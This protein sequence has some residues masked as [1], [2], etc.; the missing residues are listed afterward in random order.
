[1]KIYND[2]N[3]FI[4]VKNAIVTIGTFDGVHLGHQAIFKKMVDDAKA[5][6]GETVVVTFYPHPRLV[7]NIDSSNLKF[8]TTQEKKLSIFAK[9]GIDNV[10]I[11]HFTREFSRTGSEAFIKNYIVEK[12]K[13]ACIVVGYDHHFGKNRIGDFKL[14]YDLSNKYHFK[15]ERIPAHDVE[16]ISVSSTKI[17]RALV[18]GDVK[19]ANRLLGYEY[20]NCGIVVHGNEIGRKIGFPTANIF[21]AEQYKLISVCGVYAC[22]VAYNGKI[23]DG[24]GNVGVRPTIGNDALTIEVHIFDFDEMIYDQEICIS[25]VDRIRFEEKFKNLEALRSQLIIDREK[26]KEILSLN[27]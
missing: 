2:I 7:L 1:M 10:V 4:P 24:M 13:P 19:K 8:I 22:H 21:V 12:I 3:S 20:T 5:I 14:L 15:V 9:M 6:G 16:N 17:R 18:A 23:Y 25:F 11:I 26:A 27:Y